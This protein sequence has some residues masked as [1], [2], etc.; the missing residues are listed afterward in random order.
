MASIFDQRVPLSRIQQIDDISSNL[1]RSIVI[2]H[3]KLPKD[4]FPQKLN[5][6]R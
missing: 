4:F 2:S 5:L 3:Q 6:K 1:K